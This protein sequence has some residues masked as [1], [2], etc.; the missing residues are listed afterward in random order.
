MG[1]IRG[2]IVINRAVDDVFDFVADERNEPRYNP[3]MRSAEKISL[4]PIGVGTR[5]RAQ[6]VTMG[7]PLDMDIE[8]TGYDRPHRLESAT[9]MSSMDVHG[10][11]TFDPVPGG[12]RM[13]WS[14]VT[15]LRGV[16][17]LMGPFAMI[18]GRRQERG[19]WAGLKRVLEG[20]PNALEANLASYHAPGIEGVGDKQGSGHEQGSGAA[21]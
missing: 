6:V 4:G 15:H 20:E 5:F 16:F 19:I 12:T 7:R 3:H 13:C 1:H 10:S 18:V 17:L 21:I 9:H 8:F 2:D 11:L 14:W